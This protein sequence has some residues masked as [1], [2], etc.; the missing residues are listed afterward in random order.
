MVF[1][2]FRKLILSIFLICL[3]ISS[4]K[5]EVYAVDP[6]ESF[7]KFIARFYVDENFQLNRIRFPIEHKIYNTENSCYEKS[8][9]VKRNWN[10]TD[11]GSRKYI[12]N[13]TRI[14]DK[15]QLNIQIEETGV[16]VNYIFKKFNGQ[17]YL[18]SIVDES[19]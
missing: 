15:Q 4:P 17:W 16:S 1:C 14:K 2:R 7:D 13:I 19:T 3:S 9:L 5:G 8:K 12:K 6:A 11:F 18:I 10:Y